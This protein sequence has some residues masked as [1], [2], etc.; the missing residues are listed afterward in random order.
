MW[1]IV[2]TEIQ[3]ANVLDPANAPPGAFFVSADRFVKTVDNL[4]LA[5]LIKFVN[6]SETPRRPEQLRAN[7]E[8]CF[9]PPSERLLSLAANPR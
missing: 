3:D 9:I 4:D 6:G 5:S 1:K 8:L 2:I 7:R